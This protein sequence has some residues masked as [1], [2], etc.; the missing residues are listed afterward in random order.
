MKDYEDEKLKVYILGTGNSFSKEKNNTCFIVETGKKYMVDCP[1]A[2]LQTLDKAGIDVKE[3]NDVILT[4]N[5][6]DHKGDLETLIFQKYY[7]EGNKKLNICTTKEIF[8]ELVDSLETSTH[9]PIRD[10]ITLTEIKPYYRMELGDLVI[11]ARENLHSVAT[12]GLKISY[13]GRTLGYSSD[14]TYDPEYIKY[15]CDKEEKITTLQKANLLG[16]LWDADLILHEADIAANEIHTDIKQLEA[17]PED[18][19]KKIR[20]VHVPDNLKTELE[21]LDDFDVFEV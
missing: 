7:N 13:K 15:L 17:L 20:L 12:I 14:T 3:I 4:H 16:F 5:H 21:I 1:R 2:L 9:K 6:G 11:K 8:D 19:K 10:Y 18:V